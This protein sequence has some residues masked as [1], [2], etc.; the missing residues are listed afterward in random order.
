MDKKLMNKIP[1]RVEAAVSG[2]KVSLYLHGTV[3]AFYDGIEFSKV[4]Q[5]LADIKSDV[6]EVHLNSYGGDMFE[7]IAIKNYL[8]QREEHIRVII[9]GIAASAASVIA[10][11]GDEILMPKDTQLMIH[12]PWT[13]TAGNA[14]ELRKT[15]DNMDKAT[16][17][18]QESYLKRFV[19]DR[20]ELQALLDAETYLTAEEAVTF[21]LA[22]GL[23]ESEPKEAEPEIAEKE[24]V[25]PTAALM[26]KYGGQKIAASVEES[27]P[28]KPSNDGLLKFAKLFN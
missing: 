1:K 8:V 7:G 26:A 9:D 13:W 6:I 22:D 28:K 12:K 3:G 15:A 21:G 24:A 17:S 2:D 23:L 14:D 16:K 19:G 5:A 20:E 10:M 11:A 18:I 27:A 4:Q 25:S